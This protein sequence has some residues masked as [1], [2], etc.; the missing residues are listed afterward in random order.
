MA[1]SQNNAGENCPER[2]KFKEEEIWEEYI[3]NEFWKQRNKMQKF[4]EI[5]K[6]ETAK[7]RKIYSYEEK[8]KSRKKSKRLNMRKFQIHD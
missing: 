7:N 3:K 2:L 5:F 6:R 4:S 1:K 8:E